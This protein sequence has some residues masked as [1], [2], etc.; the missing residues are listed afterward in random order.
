[1]GRL[2]SGKNVSACSPAGNN[3]NISEKDVSSLYVRNKNIILYT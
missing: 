2:A 3:E 1:M